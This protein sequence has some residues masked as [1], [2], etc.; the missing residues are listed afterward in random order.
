MIVLAPL[1]EDRPRTEAQISRSCRYI[2][3]DSVFSDVKFYFPRQC[4]SYCHFQ[5]H[6][7]KD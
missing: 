5:C 1:W 4:Q 6:L 7:L 2:S 3:Y